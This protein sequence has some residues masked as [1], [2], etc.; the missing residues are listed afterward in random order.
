[1]KSFTR[2]LAKTLKL[3]QEQ[4]EVIYYGLFVVVTNMLSSLS[5]LFIGFCLNQLFNTFL[6][7]VFYTPLRLY[8]GGYHSKTPQSCFITYNI[9]Y[10]VFIVMMSHLSNSWIM[11]IGTFG[12]LMIIFIDLYFH[13]DSKKRKQKLILVFLHLILIILT[14]SFSLHY[15]FILAMDIN[16]LFYGMKY[17]IFPIQNKTYKK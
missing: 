6:L 14:S 3:D 7:Q 2:Y 15:I 9:V 11:D 5:V 13:D 1:M 12:L 17:L 10:F 4:E 8:V 16:I